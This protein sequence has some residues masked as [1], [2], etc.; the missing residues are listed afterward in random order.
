MRVLGGVVGGAGILERFE[1]PRKRVLIMHLL[2]KG[3]Y[4]V[5]YD[6]ARM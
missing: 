1:T 6:G 2:L 5:K 4:G 3:E